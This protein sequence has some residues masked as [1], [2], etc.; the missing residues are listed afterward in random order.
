MRVL[1]CSNPVA[2]WETQKAYLHHLHCRHSSFLL[3]QAPA[4]LEA[5]AGRKDANISC[6]GSFSKTPKCLLC[7]GDYFCFTATFKLP[8]CWFNAPVWRELLKHS[9]AVCKAG[10][11]TQQGKRFVTYQRVSRKHYRLLW[12]W[13]TV[14]TTGLLPHSLSDNFPLFFWVFF[15]LVLFILIFWHL[16]SSMSIKKSSLGSKA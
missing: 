11:S 1:T 2:G 3:R 12:L 15:S 14:H 4:H 6:V 9:R 7:L 8:A 10:C 13:C 5:E 16:A